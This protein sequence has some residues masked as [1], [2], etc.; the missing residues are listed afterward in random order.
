MTSYERGEA[1]VGWAHGRIGNIVFLTY[2][3]AV[4]EYAVERS[5]AVLEHALEVHPAG[6]GLVGVYGEQV[7]VPSSP[8]MKEIARRLAHYAGHL[9]IG[10]TVIEGD[11]VRAIAKR[12][13]TSVMTTLL[14]TRYPHKTLGSLALACDFVAP[15]AVNDR[16]ARLT[17]GAVFMAATALRCLPPTELAASGT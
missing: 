15:K 3:A 5:F 10:C 14:N 17:Q 7:P 11:T 12:T 4:P 6:V 13:A 16:G 1:G 9:V 2:Q 8:A